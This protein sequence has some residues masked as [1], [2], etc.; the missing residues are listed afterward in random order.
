MYKEIGADR[1]ATSYLQQLASFPW[2]DSSQVNDSVKRMELGLVWTPSTPQGQSGW[3][4]FMYVKAAAGL[5]AG[6]LVARALP[7]TG[8]V[9]AAGSTVAATINTI[10]GLTLNSETGYWM[11]YENGGSSP[12]PTIVPIKGNTATSAG[13]ATIT[14]SQRDLNATLNQYDADAFSAVLT[15]GT[16]STLYR[17]NSVIV[18]TATTVPIGVAL[19]TVTSGNYTVIQVAGLALVQATGNGQALVAGAP[20]VGSASG[21]AIGLASPVYSTG[22]MVALFAYTSA[23]PELIPFH[24]NF[25]GNI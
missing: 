19:G 14:N 2:Y 3:N 12:G 23:G 25:T 11:Y 5:T 22:S 24:V 13:A 8:V 9:V 4:K 6:Q 1:I 16:A 10:A 17:P 20:A 21:V 18:N 15:N 7:T